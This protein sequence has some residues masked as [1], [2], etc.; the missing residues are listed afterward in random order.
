MSNLSL[1]ARPKVSL[2]LQFHILQPSVTFTAPYVVSESSILIHFNSVNDQTCNRNIQGQDLCKRL[3]QVAAVDQ[4]GLLED[5][6]CTNEAHR[7]PPM[8]FGDGAL[9]GIRLAFGDNACAQVLGNCDV[10]GKVGFRSINAFLSRSHIVRPETAS[11]G[12]V[13]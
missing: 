10:D 8:V 7:G 6:R 4:V 5:S 11:G 3:L 12:P 1:H 13:C 2:H 9:R